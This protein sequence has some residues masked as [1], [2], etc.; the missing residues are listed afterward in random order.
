MRLIFGKYSTL[1]AEKYMSIV[2]Q[3]HMFC[4]FFIN[5]LFLN[6]IRPLMFSFFYTGNEPVF[7][8]S[9]VAFPFRFAYKGF[10]G[11]K[12]KIKTITCPSQLLSQKHSLANT[13]RSNPLL[14]RDPSFGKDSPQV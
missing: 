7:H 13:F 10:C 2:L 1:G 4:L 3:V 8:G 6:G 14:G 12:I 11:H 5:A 9:G